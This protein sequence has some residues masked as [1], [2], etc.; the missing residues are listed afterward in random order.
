MDFN[1]IWY[2]DL[3]H[4]GQDLG[5]DWIS[6]SYLIIYMH[7]G[8]SCDNHCLR[9]CTKSMP[10]HYLNL[11]LISVFDKLKS[12]IYL[13]LFS[14]SVPMILKLTT[15]TAQDWG[16]MELDVDGLMQNCGIFITHALENCSIT[17]GHWCNIYH[18]QQCILLQDGHCCFA[19]PFQLKRTWD[20]ESYF[21][22][23]DYN[24]AYAGFSNQHRQYVIQACKLFLPDV[25]CYI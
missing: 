7:N 13:K 1:D 20:M 21:I 18:P 11:C 23:M 4:L 5:W 12:S 16:L 3:C 24:M 9:I 22:E 6:A 19:G 2:I 8:Q 25:F 17:Q 15:S 14:E 10:S